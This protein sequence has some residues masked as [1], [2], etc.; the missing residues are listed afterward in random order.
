MKTGCPILWREGGERKMSQKLFV[1]FALM[2][3]LL[4][5]SVTQAQSFQKRCGWYNNPSPSNSWLIDND[6]KWAIDMPGMTATDPTGWTHF[7]KTPANWVRTSG[8]SGY[9]CACI[10]ARSDHSKHM[11]VEI[12][13]GEAKPLSDCRNDPNLTS[14]EPT[15]K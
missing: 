11:I 4:F 3:C 5:A 9:G 13:Q 7:T 10:T 8:D 14:L 12:Q 15:G 1:I 6:S 2:G